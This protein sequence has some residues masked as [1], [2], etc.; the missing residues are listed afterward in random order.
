MAMQYEAR[1][2][3]NPDLEIVAES[4]LE[5]VRK[6]GAGQHAFEGFGVIYAGCY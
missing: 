1:K 3:I 5:E 4:V 2:H 6:K